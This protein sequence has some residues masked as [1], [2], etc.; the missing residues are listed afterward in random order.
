LRLDSLCD[1]AIIR[2]GGLVVNRVLA[3]TTDWDDEPTTDMVRVRRLTM[4][5]STTLF[6]SVVSCAG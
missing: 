6:A 4:D 5:T 1:A 3:C 2:L